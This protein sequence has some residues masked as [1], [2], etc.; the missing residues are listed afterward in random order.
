VFESL[1]LEGGV[2][3]VSQDV[4][5]FDFKGPGGL[6]RPP[7]FVDELRILLLEELV[8]MGTF[9]ELLVDEPVLSRQCLDVLCQLSDL[10]SFQ[11]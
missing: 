6:L 5:L 8:S 7:F 4:L 1:Y 9:S 3:I 11:L 10:L 2:T